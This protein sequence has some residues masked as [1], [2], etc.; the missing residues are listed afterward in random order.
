MGNLKLTTDGA[1]ERGKGKL[2]PDMGPWGENPDMGPW[3]EGK[4]S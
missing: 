2:N 3:G 1:M 4:D